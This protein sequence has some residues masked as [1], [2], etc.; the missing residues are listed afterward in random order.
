MHFEAHAGLGWI[1][2]QTGQINRKLRGLVLIA[3]VIPDL[4]AITYLGGAVFYTRYHHVIFHNLLFFVVYSV[5]SAYL[6]RENRLKALI[7]TQL[8]L[9]LHFFGDYFFTLYPQQLFFPFSSKEFLY[10]GAVWLGHPI[11]TLFAYGSYVVFIMVAFI[12]KRTPIE[13]FSVNLDQRIV[14][15]FFRRRLSTCAICKIKSN[16]LCSHCG[17]PVCRKHGLLRKGFVIVCESC[18]NTKSELKPVEQA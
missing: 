13:L 11:N 7:Y 1:I 16:E 9:W 15:L 12:F 4:D 8:A 3:A 17:Q 18:C 5:F 10:Q 2:G 6:C 14:N